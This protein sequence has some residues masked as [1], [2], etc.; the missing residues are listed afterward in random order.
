MI[1]DDLKVTDCS[2]CT[3]A[4]KYKP[5]SSLVLASYKKNKE[6]ILVPHT[7]ASL[8]RDVGP[9]S[10]RHG[11]ASGQKTALCGGGGEGSYRGLGV[12]GGGAMLEGVRTVAVRSGGGGTLPRAADGLDGTR[13]SLERKK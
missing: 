2:A 1:G 3:G 4:F 5:P 9:R 13:P 6:I 7:P 12:E 8:L 10:R 11:A